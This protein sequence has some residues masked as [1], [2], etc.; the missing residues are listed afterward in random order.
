L[1]N[2]KILKLADIVLILLILTVLISLWLF[3]DGNTS[4]KA[5]VY[6]DGAVYKEISLDKIQADE[7]LI[8]GDVHILITSEGISITESDCPDKTC[9]KSG[10]V[11]KSG[12]TVACVPNKIV[13]TVTKN[14][15]L[16][17]GVTG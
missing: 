16:I 2:I 14:D 6:V 8:I 5:T 10:T 15:A 11:K 1:K 7:T 9:V 12:T 4:N 13:I 17:D 3:N